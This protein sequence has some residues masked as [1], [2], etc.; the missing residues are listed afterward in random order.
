MTGDA[1]LA[2]LGAVLGDRARARILLALGDGRA[3]AA[4]VLA[5]EAGVAAS[6]ASAHL[7]RL[8]D[9]GLLAVA[10]QGRHRYYRLAGPD[11]AELLERLG[12]I[13]VPSMARRKLTTSAPSEL[14]HARSCYDHLAGRLGV[15]IH[16]FLL[17]GGH[18]VRDYDHHLTVT[19]S[20]REVLEGLGVDV[21][22]AVRATRPTARSCVDWTE[23]RHHL[24]GATGAALFDALLARRWLVR[25]T[26][27]RSVRVTTA[28]QRGLDVLLA[29]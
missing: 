17:D 16:D 18:L 29:S 14:L 1:D 9:A 8:V 28:G 3:L 13:E 10:V 27:P 21:D 24:A 25:G 4:S 6:T 23:R 26:R 15:R 20:G 19:P 7:A 11:V 22:A 2:A 12:A 5:S